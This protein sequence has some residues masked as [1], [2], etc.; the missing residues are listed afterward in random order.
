VFRDGK[1]LIAQRF[2][3]AHCGGLWEFP[4][5][6]R[7]PG[8]SFEQCLARELK[9]ELGIEAAV[10]ELVESLRHDYPEK[11]VLL[12]FYRC[13]WLRNEPRPIY[14]QDIAWIQ[15]CQL[16]SYTFP[17]ADARLLDLVRD[18]ADLWK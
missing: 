2:D 3:N 4:G 12:K 16:A 10:G 9:E 5:G 14:C 1:L 11:S 8:E 6:K 18:N 17:A 15:R 13:E 7:E